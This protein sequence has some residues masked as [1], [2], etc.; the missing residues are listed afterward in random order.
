MDKSELES[1][2]MTAL[3][4]FYAIS[5]VIGATLYGIWLGGEKLAEKIKA[6]KNRRRRTYTE[7]TEYDPMNV[8]ADWKDQA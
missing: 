1:T 5:L 4:K 3:L 6:W 7:V 8:V 2:I